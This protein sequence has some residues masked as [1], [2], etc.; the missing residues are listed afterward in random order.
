M[1][2]HTYSYNGGG[3]E[4]GVDTCFGVIAHDKSAKL[5]V[6]AEEAAGRIIPQFNFAVIVLRLED[7]APAP[8]LHH[9]PITAFPKN[10]SWALLENP[11]MTTLFNSP[12]TLQY[13]PNVV[14]P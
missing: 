14:A 13:G 6:R 12:P 7:T 1:Y 4:H 2:I 11:N 10:P 3:V 5:Q 8:K 9:S